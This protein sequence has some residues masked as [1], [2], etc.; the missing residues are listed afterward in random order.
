MSSTAELPAWIVPPPQGFT[1]DDLDRLTDLPPH[2][3]LI[4]GSLVLVGPQTI[5]HTL[6]L[7]LLVAGL[8]RGHWLTRR[9]RDPPRPA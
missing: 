3:E 2:T 6:V 5:F 7:D 4:D 8:R 1:A 9:H